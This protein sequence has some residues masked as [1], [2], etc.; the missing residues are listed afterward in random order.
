M[1]VAVYHRLT[2]GAADDSGDSLKPGF[3]SVP[4]SS[5][6]FHT[7]DPLGGGSTQPVAQV[8]PRLAVVVKGA[9]PDYPFDHVFI[10]GQVGVQVKDLGKTSHVAQVCNLCSLSLLVAQVFNLCSLS[11]PVA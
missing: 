9:F 4:T 6:D 11:L 8:P 2:T 5:Q 10:I 1:G 3:T 7:L